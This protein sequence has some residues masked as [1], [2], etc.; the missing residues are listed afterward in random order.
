M[1]WRQS[2]CAGRIALCVFLMVANLC[3]ARASDWPQWRGPNHNGIS[4]EKN[5]FSPWPDSGPAQAWSV[6]V[7]TGFSTVA[8]QDGRVFTMGNRN[9]VDTVF[10]LDAETGEEIWSHSYPC[11]LQPRFYEGGPSATPTVHGDRV[12]TFSKKGHIH[13]FKAAS[14]EVLWSRNLREDLDLELPEWSFAGSPLI[15][16][17]LLILNAGSAGTALHKDTGEIVWTSGKTRS[18]YATPVP[19]QLNGKP[20]VAI[21]SAT[22]LVAVRPASG[23]VFWEYPWKSPRDINAADPIIFEDKVF[24]SSESGSALLQM[25]EEE[26]ILLW[27]HADLMRNYFNPAVLIDGYLY[28][29]DGTTHRPTSLTCINF[30]TGEVQWSQPGFGS[31]ALMAADNKLIIFDKGELTIVE[32]G[33]EQFTLLARS[34]IMGG[35]CWTVPV[36]ADGRIYCRNATGLLVCVAVR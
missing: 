19:F 9:D 23:E 2:C 1:N 4:E 16:E 34:Q 27:R 5:W 35:K 12:Y 28:A 36:L 11:N 7:G 25:N 22:A 14:G 20:A 24:I 18:G 31:G 8:V 30:D 21:F 13:A 26:A 6:Q 33:P 32:A 3:L 10:C 29:I 17:K 15:H